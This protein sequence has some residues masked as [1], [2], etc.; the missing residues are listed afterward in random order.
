MIISVTKWHTISNSSISRTAR[1]LVMCTLV[2]RRCWLS[3]LHLHLV[4]I[5]SLHYMADRMGYVCSTGKCSYTFLSPTTVNS[6]DFFGAWLVAVVIKMYVEWM[7]VCVCVWGLLF[8]ST[9]NRS[10]QRRVFTG[11][12][13]HRYWQPK[14]IKHSTTYTRN[15]KEK[16]KKLPY[17]TKQSTPWF[18]MAFTIS[19]QETE[20]ALFLQPRSPNGAKMYVKFQLV[21]VMGTGLQMCTDQTRIQTVE[22]KHT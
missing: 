13:L 21:L 8:H 11:N 14:T 10:L 9:H 12:R 18:G 3:E 15:T 7:S 19:G 17:L 16:Q 20:W 2:T 5:A 4:N 6:N 1:L 22:V